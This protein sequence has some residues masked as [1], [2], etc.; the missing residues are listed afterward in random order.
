MRELLEAMLGLKCS[1]VDVSLTGLDHLDN[2]ATKYSFGVSVADFKV[3]PKAQEGKGDWSDKAEYVDLDNPAG[4]YVVYLAENMEKAENARIAE[5]KLG[6]NAF[7]K[8]LSIPSCCR[9]FYKANREEALKIGDDYLWFTLPKK[10]VF[11]TVPA[12][13]NIIGQYFDA[14]FIS[15]YPCCISCQLTRKESLKRKQVLSLVSESFV[16]DLEEGHKKSYLVIK[17]KLIICLNLKYYAQ[18]RLEFL[19][20]ESS[21]LV[22]RLPDKWE[23]S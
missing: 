12:G 9:K 20:L 22:G 7:G 11:N 14:C 1:R 15:H 6:D 23:K 13:A 4:L 17:G 2:L 5:S 19:P 18:K 8:M 10:F 16:T 21:I 3:I